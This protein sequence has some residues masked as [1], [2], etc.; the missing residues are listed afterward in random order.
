MVVVQEKKCLCKLEAV[1]EYCKV[2]AWVY[3]DRSDDAPEMDSQDSQD[4]G[5]CPKDL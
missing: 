5:V 2:Q 1:K 3:Y 4:H